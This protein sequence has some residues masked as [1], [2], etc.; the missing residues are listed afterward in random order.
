MT[1]DEM[2]HE[3]PKL[4]GIRGREQTAEQQSDEHQHRHPADS[5]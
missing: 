4:A 2:P 5:T 3:P 1:A